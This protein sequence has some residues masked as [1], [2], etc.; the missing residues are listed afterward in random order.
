MIQVRR[1]LT[2]RTL[3]GLTLGLWIVLLAGSTLLARADGP[4]WGLHV[5]LADDGRAVAEPTNAVGIAWQGEVRP[6]MTLLTVEGQDARLFAGRDLPTSTTQLTFIDASGAPRTIEAPDISES[7]LRF[8]FVGAFAFVALGAVVYRWSGDPVLGRLFMLLSAS[9]A[10][11]LVAA[12]AARMGFGLANFVSPVAALL[13][14]PGLFGLFLRFPRPLRASRPLAAASIAIALAL[15][16]IQLSWSA[17][18]YQVAPSLEKVLDTAAW[19]WLMFNLLGALAL[20]ATRA[21]RPSDRRPLAPLLVGTAVGIGPLIFLHALPRLLGLTPVPVELT[22]MAMAAIPVSFAYSILRHQVLGL[23]AMMRRMVL[24]TTRV[25][26]GVVVFFGGW[27][28]L[29]TTG[30]PSVEAAL[31]AALIGG[32]IMPTLTNWSSWLVDAWLYRSLHRMRGI[33]E[34]AMIDSLEG[35]GASVAQRLR[36]VLPVTWTAVVIHDD[37]QPVDRASRRL[38]GGDGR[39]PAWLGSGDSLDNNTSNT[40]VCPIVHFD[41]GV[42]L[43]LAGPRLDG[44]HLDGIQQEA[45]RVLASTVRA[46]FEASLLRERAEDDARFR[47]GLTD[48]ARDLAAAATV[49][50]VLRSFIIHAA[51]LLR[52]ESVTL[53]RGGLDGTLLILDGTTLADRPSDDVLRELSAAREARSREREWTALA[54][55]GTTLAFALDDGGDQPLVC[56]VARGDQATRFGSLDEH[57]AHELT[58]HTTGA[59]RRAAE[60]QVLEEQLRHRAFYDSLTGLPN[61]SLF[62]DRVAHGLARGEALGQQIAVLFIDLDRFKVVNDSLGHAAGDQLLMQVGRRLRTCLR[63]SDTM[64]RLGGDE[65]TVLLEGPQA[66][67]DAVQAAERIL[68]TLSAPFRLDG[69]ETY[70]AA[71]IGISGGSAIREA[72]RDLLREADIALYRAKAAGRGR[73]IVFEPRMNHLPAEHLHLE[74]DLHRAIERNELRL[75]YQPI[76]NLADGRITSLEALVRWEHPEKG[77]VPPMQFIPLAEDTGLI[78]PIGK[79]VLEEACR[80]MREWQ[81][82]Y[83][84]AGAENLA[85]SVNVSARQ[86]QD[87]R[88]LADVEHAVQ[89]AGLDPQRLQLEITESVVMQE[90]EATVVKLNA[91]KGLGIKL[92]VDD[93]GTGYSSLAYLKRFPIDVLKIDRAF[94]AGLTQGGHDAAIVQ[95]VIGLARALGLRT[96]AEGIEEQA[97]WSLLEQLGCDQGQGFLFSRPLRPEAVPEMLDRLGGPNRL[98]VAA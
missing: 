45:M 94:V 36:H 72:G 31:L 43:L 24:R 21:V 65:F 71:S 84:G 93:F 11:A 51:R 55:R 75:H 10:T 97:Q 64:A 82:A 27:A 85:V 63:E 87:P 67:A 38:L 98:T 3:V 56:V 83:A 44:D 12:P 22:A 18:G 96:T 20:L 66:V 49:D 48:L 39:L 8:L 54:G 70:A 5:G 73:Y 2:R 52:A 57:R 29:Q 79:W 90:P 9:F 59:L 4:Q 74:S 89:A 17:R 6:Q 33:S 46:Q 41:S 28:A 16:A 32:V 15:S 34:Q 91:L 14:A 50:D 86:L 88:L 80:Q 61:R 30:L 62:L 42:V 81:T 78:V 95:T 53:W 26:L 60:R 76:F 19:L 69:Q 58:E 77:L 37:T 40:S 35:L 92:A 25:S 23:D 68:A 1:T 13:A 47:Q 7:S